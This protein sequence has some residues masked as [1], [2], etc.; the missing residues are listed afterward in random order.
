MEN[1]PQHTHIEEHRDRTPV[2]FPGAPK[3]KK[4]NVGVKIA[5]LV[6]LLLVIGG[7]AWFLLKS[8]SPFGSATLSPTPT[9][10]LVEMPTEAPTPTLSVSKEDLKVQVLN[11]TGVPGEAAFLQKEMEK[12]GFKSI[13]A[14]NA[15]SKDH[16]KTEVSFS[17]RVPDSIRTEVTTKLQELY[18]SVDI[19]SASAAGS[20]IKVITSTRKGQSSAKTPT[21]TTKKTTGT[22]TPTTKTTGSVTPATTGSTTPTKTPTPTP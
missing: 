21:P 10:G 11:G 22:P 2:S 13:E 17:A 8:D 6:T 14:A 9:I 19:S 1:E 18:A 16:T 20:D 7:I 4:K 5:I 15:D 12:L 3:P